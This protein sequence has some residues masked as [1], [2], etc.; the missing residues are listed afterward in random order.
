MNGGWGGGRMKRERKG[1]G[2]KGRS[3]NSQDAVLRPNTGTSARR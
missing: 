2:G 1:K 3:D